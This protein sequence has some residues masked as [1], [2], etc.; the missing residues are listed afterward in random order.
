MC[1]SESCYSWAA[2]VAITD[3][4]VLVCLG[5]CCV[6][7]SAVATLR[8]LRSQILGALFTILAVGG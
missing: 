2:C 8:A 1:S 7:L 6:V 4:C 5:C 3:D